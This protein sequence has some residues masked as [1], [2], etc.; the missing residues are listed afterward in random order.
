MDEHTPENPYCSN[1][2]CWCHTDSDYGTLV[3]QEQQAEAEQQ[4]L[5]TFA[6]QFLGGQEAK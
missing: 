5:A 4:Q 1:P 6:Y 3:E 2:D